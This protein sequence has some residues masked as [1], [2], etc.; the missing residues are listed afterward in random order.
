MVEYILMVSVSVMIITVL[1]Q[2]MYKPMDQFVQSIMGTYIQC[3]LETG[4]LPQLGAK[5]GANSECQVFRFDVAPGGEV[6]RETTAKKEQQE[7]DSDKVDGDSG[8]SKGGRGRTRHMIPGG[9]RAAG[10]APFQMR[11]GRGTAGV[12]GGDASG[13]RRIEIALEGGGS[14][15]YFRSSSSGSRG[16]YRREKYVAI[17]GAMAQ[18]IAKKNQPAERT[19]A[20]VVSESGG[21]SK[22]PTKLALRKPADDKKQDEDMEVAGLDI[23]Q[24][25]KFILIAGIIIVLVV[26]I[27][28]QAMQLSKSWEKGE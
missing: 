13:G 7:A 18:E 20:T 5:T 12:D 16:G 1:V 9:S 4:E 2:K 26:L 23:S 21:A 27:G 14:G 3:L 6:T 15:G 28:G 25:V 11:G 8:G 17:T 19:R 10:R 22:R 24:I